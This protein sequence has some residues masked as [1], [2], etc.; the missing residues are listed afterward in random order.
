MQH[1]GLCTVTPLKEGEFVDQRMANG[2]VPPIEQP[3]RTWHP[4]DISRVEVTVHESIYDATRCELRETAFEV[5]EQSVD[6]APLPSV[7]AICI[8]IIDTSDSWQKDSWPPV[9]SAQGDKLICSVDPLDLKPDKLVY[10]LEERVIRGFVLVNSSNV[11]QQYPAGLKTQHL[12][13]NFG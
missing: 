12:R 11:T 8:Q 6:G 2:A 3:K 1:G 10:H 9:P 5:G 7:E 13:H 4:S